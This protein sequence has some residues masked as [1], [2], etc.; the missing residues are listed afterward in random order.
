MRGV[1]CTCMRRRRHVVAPGGSGRGEWCQRTPART[2]LLQRLGRLTHELEALLLAPRLAQHVAQRK[3]RV[4]RRG[5]ARGEDTE[6]QQQQQQRRQ[7]SACRLASSGAARKRATLHAAAHAEGAKPTVGGRDP[8]ARP[9]RQAGKAAC[10]AWAHGR[11]HQ[12]GHSPVQPQPILAA[13]HSSLNPLEPRQPG[14]YPRTRSGA[15]Q[16][17]PDAG[18]GHAPLWQWRPAQ[19]SRHRGGPVCRMRGTGARIP[20]RWIRP[21]ESRNAFFACARL[22]TLRRV[23]DCSCGLLRKG[24]GA[25]R[26]WPSSNVLDTNSQSISRTHLEV[27]FGLAAERQVVEGRHVQPVALAVGP[28]QQLQRLAHTRDQKVIRPS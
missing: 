15:A 7:P 22:F 1:P 26:C 14:P 17:W 9:P 27:A 10:G 13:T 25:S 11:A 23:P 12:C 16:T 6:Q 18:P 2:R 28:L 20:V 4:W 24:A 3:Q 21:R 19:G 8:R 5:G